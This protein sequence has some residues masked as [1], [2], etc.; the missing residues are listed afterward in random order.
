[1][2]E[3]HIRGVKDTSVGRGTDLWDGDGLWVGGGVRQLV[4]NGANGTWVEVVVA[5][6]HQREVVTANGSG[7]G[8]M[9][10]N[11]SWMEVDRHGVEMTMANSIG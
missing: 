11:G 3:G 8:V 10:A 7:V 2:G 4:K 6:R 5:C 9:V 1:M